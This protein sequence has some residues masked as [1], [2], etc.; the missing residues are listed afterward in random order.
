MGLLSDVLRVAGAVVLSVA[1]W[2]ILVRILDAARTAQTALGRLRRRACC[3]PR[4]RRRWTVRALVRN[5]RNYFCG[6][7]GI[8]RIGAFQCPEVT[9]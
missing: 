6:V 9:D 8:F 3:G 1:Y 5:V 2:C 7:L 4:F